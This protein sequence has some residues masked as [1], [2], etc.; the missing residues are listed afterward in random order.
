MDA[1]PS[2]AFLQQAVATY[3]AG[4]ARDFGA[5]WSLPE[6]ASAS[7]E[8]HG[9]RHARAHAY[10]HIHT[11]THA[12]KSIYTRT[13]KLTHTH[14]HTNVHTHTHTH[15]QLYTHACTLTC[16]RHTQSPTDVLAK[17]EEACLELASGLAAAGAPTHIMQV[18]MRVWCV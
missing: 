1:S 14:T 3:T 7:G 13:H 6:G 11:C 12:I 15:M 17:D 8:L 4:L 2:D 10:T 5:S 16:S 18:C 9:G